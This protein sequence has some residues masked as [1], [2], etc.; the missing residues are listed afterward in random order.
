MATKKKVVKKT[1][2]KA[3][4]KTSGKVVKKKVKKKAASTKSSGKKRVTV[5]LE[6]PG[7]DRVFLLGSFNGWEPGK[8]EMKK[9]KK[10][11]WSKSLLLSPG[12]YEYKFMVDG[13]WWHDPACEESV[14]NQ[15]GTLNSLLRV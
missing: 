12:T 13:D 9:D 6:A 4:K 11:I 15:F 1:S 5:T 3:A 7:A 2:K 8:H 10:G 14:F